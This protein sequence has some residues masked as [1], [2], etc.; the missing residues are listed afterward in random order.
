MRPRGL[1]PGAPG[2]PQPPA[3]AGQRGHGGEGVSC[4][5]RGAAGCAWALR[6]PPPRLRR[7]G[8]AGPGGRRACP[9]RPRTGSGAAGETGG[10]GCEGA[11]SGGPSRWR[12]EAPAREVSGG[13]VHSRGPGAGAG[14]ELRRAPPSPPREASPCSA[15]AFASQPRDRLNL[16]ARRALQRH[17]PQPGAAVQGACKFRVRCTVRGG[18]GSPGSRAIPAEED[19]PRRSLPL[20]P[21]GDPCS[22]QRV[23]KGQPRTVLCPQGARGPC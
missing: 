22:A 23:C 6:F 17:S 12:S 2:R 10:G 1:A 3:A 21:A 20:T 15:G 5:P 8:G 13:F 19:L 16:G 18:Q 9:L 4:A 7:S 14:C 11:C